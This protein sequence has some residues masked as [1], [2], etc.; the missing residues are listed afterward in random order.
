MRYHDGSR[1]DFSEEFGELLT[2]Y[3]SEGESGDGLLASAY[4]PFVPSDTE[5]IRSTVHVIR[6]QAMRF[7]LPYKFAISE[8]KTKLVILQEEFRELG[9][10]N[11]IDTVTTR[12]K[13]F[14]S[15]LE[16]IQ[17]R[18]FNGT[19]E[20]L[21]AEITDIAGIRVT[22]SFIS[23]VYTVR[24]LLVSQ[25]DVTLVQE[26]D[27]IEH[28]KG[29]GYRSL[30]LLLQIPVFLSSGPEPTI[31]EVQIRTKAMDFWA[32]LEHKIYYKYNSDVPQE[33]LDGLR[34]AAITANELDLKMQQLHRA[35]RE[36]DA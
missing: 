4:E 2:Q 18:H 19:I 5:Q 12:L 6:A 11:P 36:T 22:C 23:D 34:E 31:A 15:I 24:D 27:Y 13:S 14:E 10:Y 3:A 28:P 32:S 33:Y 20:Q 9:T 30:H 17:R 16:K 25:D 35:I 21:K 7:M 29:N 26:K 8:I 1:G